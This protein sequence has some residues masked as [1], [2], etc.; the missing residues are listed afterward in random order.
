MHTITFEYRGGGGRESDVLHLPAGLQVPLETPAIEVARAD[1]HPVV[2]DD[3]LRMQHA[4]LVFEDFDA[5]AQHLAVIAARRM[6]NPRMIGKWARHQQPDVD[7]STGRA[8]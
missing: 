4:R 2:G 7:T 1:R 5:V 8:A 3:H 6:A